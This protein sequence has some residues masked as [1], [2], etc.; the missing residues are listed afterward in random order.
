MA[1]PRFDGLGTGF[2]RLV[3]VAA[4]TGVVT[5]P[6]GVDV[7]FTDLALNFANGDA[8]AD[9]LDLLTTWSRT[10]GIYLF[11]PTQVIDVE[12]FDFVTLRS[13]L[14]ELRQSP[15]YRQVRFLWV[16]NPSE[17]LSQWQLQSLSIDDGRVSRQSTFDLGGY[18]LT[19]P[20]GTTIVPSSA[21]F[22][23]TTALAY[24]T[25]D[26]GAHQLRGVGEQIQLPLV[27][28]RIG[29]WQFDLTL[30]RSANSTY[31]ELA[32]LDIGFRV[33]FADP[34]LSS[35]PALFGSAAFYQSL[36]Y[37]LFDETAAAQER[38]PAD[39]KLQGSW[40]PLD[41]DRSS[42]T[43]VP[44]SGNTLPSLPSG[45]RSNL[46]YTVYLTPQASS[47]LVFA[48]KP[49][50]SLGPAEGLYLTPQGEFGL[51]I[52]RHDDNPARQLPDYGN[53]LMCGLSG[54]EYIKLLEAG[55]YTIGFVPGHPAF[56]P[57]YTPSQ[58]V[59][60]RLRDLVNILT[61]RSVNDLNQRETLSSLFDPNRAEEILFIRDTLLGEFFPLDY[62][63]PLEATEA[64]QQLSSSDLSTLGD[65]EQWFQ[66][67]L[68]ASRAKDDETGMTAAA[69]TTQASATT[70]WAYV[71]RTDGSPTYYAQPDQSI[72][73]QPSRQTSLMN[74][75]EVPATDLEN[76]SATNLAVANDVTVETIPDT[77]P[78][79][80]YGSLA[81]AITDCRELELQVVN[82]LRRAKIQQHYEQQSVS[83]APV[84][85]VR[86]AAV[87]AVGSSFRTAASTAAITSSNLVSA[88]DTTTET[89]SGTTPQGL[90]AR[91]TTDYSLM[92]ELVLAR[93]TKNEQT[94]FL[95]FTNIERSSALWSAFQANQLLL[96]IDKA[97]A[98]K[99]S[100][101][102]PDDPNQTI[103]QLTIDGWTFYLDTVD[104]A[105]NILWRPESILIFKYY[106]KSLLELIE[107][108]SLWSQA[109]TFVGDEAKIAEVRQRVRASLESAIANDTE[110]IPLKTRKRYAPL[111][112]IAR[113][114]NWSGII[115]LNIPVP[116][117][118]GLPPELVALAGGIKE[119]NF[120]AQ[121]VGIDSTPIHPDDNG[122]LVVE[123]SSL[124][125]LIDYEDDQ[126]PEPHPSGYNFQV[127]NL[128]VLFQNS[129]VTDFASQIAVT[130][131]KLFEERTQLQEDFSVSSLTNVSGRNLVN[132]QGSAENHNGRTTY[133]FSFSGNNRFL[134]PN[135]AIFNY[136]DIV[137]AQFSSDPIP[138]GDN[139]TITGRFSF[140]TK[141]N[142]RKLEKFDIF[143]FGPDGDFPTQ[144]DAQQFLS[145]ANL[146]VTLSFPRDDANQ[147][148][149]AFVPDDLSFN[150]KSSDFRNNSLYAKFPITLTGFIQ[151]QDKPKGFLPIKTAL[152]NASLSTDVTWYGLSFDLDLGNLGALASVSK[153]VSD[154]VVLWLPNPN[155]EADTRPE[156]QVYVGM[157][158]PGLSGDVLGFPLQSVIKLSF[159][160][161]ELLFDP[162]DGPDNS[163]YL[164]KLKA[165][166]LKLLVLSLPPNGQT[167]LL[168]FG[169]SQGRDHPIGWYAAYAKEP[170][171]RPP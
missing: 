8:Q 24:L 5:T 29:A 145:A 132:L 45:Y 112:N 171:Q 11:L 100:F 103:T 119:E 14:L 44:L 37:P 18:A 135:S 79:F 167:E 69:L 110:D 89:I 32:S 4:D 168:I 10:A 97:E 16:N 78:I 127:L 142:F 159:K 74:F 153:F 15:A 131:D 109:A 118:E 116:P 140:W 68:R 93:S 73:Y 41:C 94:Q 136:I 53:N 98:L 86:T 31:A 161:A 152:G 126:P 23:G 154:L 143:S 66:N 107:Q 30:A 96:V 111:A 151:G 50:S 76:V 115:G 125:G 1:I 39:L 160:T 134:M 46:G 55:T 19:L 40:D 63:L 156:P 84:A 137:K 62:Q 133:A 147:R 122:A 70:A 92:R 163:T 60:Q 165:I 101:N 81:T 170:A 157:K 144:T 57:R 106:N 117:A 6:A 164:L 139:P 36:R 22:T 71:R 27:G 169:N 48:A 65:F 83:E 113:N 166:V 87:S 141:F 35:D 3:N 88:A 105:G 26:Y 51:T 21:G 77:F 28:P 52:P 99:S 72:L 130:L 146:V 2:Y 114:P 38:Y 20:R 58:G 49:A 102:D 34:L 42:F 43:F 108:P 80:P 56:A 33:F 162:A 61:Q 67:A 7:L 120:F 124:F 82:P 85:N 138:A 121:Y 158:L 91:F 104:D 123:P 128:R 59:T 75:L 155:P 150:L 54:V 17:S 148:S 90:L 64:L 149:F 9:N 129:R 13:Q 95:K 25:T 47:Q 12:T